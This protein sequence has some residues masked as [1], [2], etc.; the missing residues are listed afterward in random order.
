MGTRCPL[1]PWPC[2]THSRSC[3][4]RACRGAWYNRPR[5]P[6]PCCC[7]CRP[8]AAAPLDSLRWHSSLL[9]TQ[10]RRLGRPG[11]PGPALAALA[12]QRSGYSD[13]SQWRR[14][15]Q[16]ALPAHAPKHNSPKHI[17]TQTGAAARSVASRSRGGGHGAPCILHAPCG[18]CT[19]HTYCT[20]CG[21]C[22]SHTCCTRCALRATLAL[23][24]CS[25]LQKKKKATCTHRPH[26]TH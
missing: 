5:F 9:Q 13:A 3:N 22:T 21:P 14:T 2:C 8:A 18:P 16:P 1:K 20:P 10:V 4:C 12:A 7:A 17:L 6:V 26:R 11:R 24:H 15:P 25:S 23:S 19:S